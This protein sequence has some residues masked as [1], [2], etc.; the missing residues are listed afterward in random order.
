MALSRDFKQTV[1]ARVKCDPAF[2]QALLDEAVSL[3]LNGEPDAAKLILRDLVNA[4]IG[5][6][7]LSTEVHKPSKSLHRMLSATG[8]PTIANFSAIL[9]S[10]KKA[11]KVDIKATVLAA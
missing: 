5:F 4:T 11:M 10:L 2:A 9:A 3:L 6:E 8:N 7:A 1:V